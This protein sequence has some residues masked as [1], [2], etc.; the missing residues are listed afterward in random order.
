MHSYFLY[1]TSYTMLHLKKKTSGL[2]PQLMAQ[3]ITIPVSPRDA[4]KVNAISV[5]GTSGSLRQDGGMGLKLLILVDIGMKLDLL[6]GG[7]LIGCNW[8]N[9]L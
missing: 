7:N 3:Q 9:S 1:H 5:L 6:L 2:H 8:Y 4:P